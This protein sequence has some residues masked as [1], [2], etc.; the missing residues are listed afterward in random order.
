M[1]TA[2]LVFI[3]YDISKS[4]KSGADDIIDQLLQCTLSKTETLKA[5]V[6]IP[7]I[8]SVSEVPKTTL[9]PDDSLR[10]FTRFR[11]AVILTFTV[12]Y[13]PIMQISIRKR[14]MS[15]SIGETRHKLSDVPL[16]VELYRHI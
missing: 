13:S 10:G 11:K 4:T 7:T 5:F 14:H 2:I 6:I 12:Y 3:F 15:R 1:I 16:P 9:G 8:C